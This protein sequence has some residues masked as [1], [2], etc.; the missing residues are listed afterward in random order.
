ML[1]QDLENRMKVDALRIKYPLPLVNPWKFING[2][3]RIGDSAETID[4][5]KPWLMN[6]LTWIFDECHCQIDSMMDWTCLHF[7]H[8]IGDDPTVLAFF[9]RRRNA[10]SLDSLD[11]TLL[12]CMLCRFHNYT[13][14]LLDAGAKVDITNIQL[15]QVVHQD[16]LNWYHSRL[17]KRAAIYAFLHCMS[18]RGGRLDLRACAPR[19]IQILI[20]KMIWAQR[21]EV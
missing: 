11:A 17:E 7:T 19:D 16:V 15:L 9:L 2:I 10:F 1:K 14:R 20:A 3:L 8:L 5:Y 21:F 4:E 6:V 12:S 13:K 18:P